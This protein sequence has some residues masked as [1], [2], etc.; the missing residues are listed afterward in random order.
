MT[1]SSNRRT[2]ASLFHNQRIRCSNTR[3]TS[4]NSLSLIDAFTIFPA[5]L[6]H[7]ALQYFPF[8]VV[9]FFARI[10]GLLDYV[11]ITG[12]QRRA[13]KIMAVG[14]P[15][16]SIAVRVKSCWIRMGRP[17][18][19]YSYIRATSNNRQPCYLTLPPTA[20]HNSRTSKIPKAC[21]GISK[22]DLAYLRTTAG[23]SPR[24][25]YFKPG[26]MSL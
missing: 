17:K 21:N 2:L 1:L 18:L 24:T 9:N 4:R 3:G 13:A 14:L 5:H 22:S 20:S 7:S 15:R 8:A 16:R 10:I 23:G 25:R 11:P 19:P 26:C 12:F 6:P